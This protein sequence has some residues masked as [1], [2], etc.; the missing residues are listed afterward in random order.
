MLFATSLV[1]LIAVVAFLA[2]TAV[3]RT[4]AAGRHWAFAFL[5]LGVAAFARFAAE[6]VDADGW[7]ALALSDVCTASFFGAMWGG[8]RRYNGRRSVVSTTVW[9]L[10][11]LL[12]AVTTGIAGTIGEPVMRTLPLMVVS[13]VLAVLGAIELRRGRLGRSDTLLLTIVLGATG[14]VSALRCAVILLPVTLPAGAGQPT[15]VDGA[16]MMSLAVV[17]TMTIG[18]RQAADDA[19]ESQPTSLAAD[20]RPEGMLVPDTFQSLL[21]LLARRAESRGE[22]IAVLVMSTIDI[23]GVGAALGAPRQERFETA[24]RESWLSRLPVGA[25]PGEPGPGCLAAILAP[26]TVGEARRIGNRVYG[27]VVEDLVRL[28]GTLL[29]VTGIGIAL[30]GSIPAAELVASAHAAAIASTAS[31]ARGDLTMSEDEVI[32]RTLPPHP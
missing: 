3:R 26:S 22:E 21:S 23:P 1:V 16:I 24:W 31:A 8:M 6:A 12:L 14:L 18:S 17:G 4:R 7:G 10:L 11:A 2:G 29:P 25:L 9:V 32:E 20:N 30:S 13:G 27:Q 15:L 5:A 28:D 19:V